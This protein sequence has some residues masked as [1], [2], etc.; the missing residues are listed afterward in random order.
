[1]LWSNA[2][3]DDRLIGQ[4]LTG[5]AGEYGYSYSS[6]RFRIDESKYQT[7][8][9][10]ICRTGRCR[11]RDP[12][13]Q[14]PGT[15]V[16]WDDGEPWTF[17]LEVRKAARSGYELAGSFQRKADDGEQRMELSEPQI[18][19][20]NGLL[21]ARGNI[22]RV[23]HRG[24]FELL[25]MLREKTALPLAKNALPDLLKTLCE[26]PR[27]PKMNWPTDFLVNE[28]EPVPRPC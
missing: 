23:E 5:C 17:Q 9:Q 13:H 1:M 6:T 27:L 18:I 8:L 11:V 28:C 2:P 15:V 7:I 21:I 16:S 25:A 10:R 19:L 22:S 4:M 20:L 3:Q 26:M 14:Q 24:A 12:R